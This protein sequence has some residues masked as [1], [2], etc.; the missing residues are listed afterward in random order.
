MTSSIDERGTKACGKREKR[1]LGVSSLAGSPHANI[2]AADSC[3]EAAGF[4]VGW[5]LG[6]EHTANCGQPKAV[7]VGVVVTGTAAV[8][9]D[10][11]IGSEILQT[12]T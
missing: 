3:E 1:L 5:S 11:G 7:L 4:E 9:L 12:G 6:R 8:T 10:E 2:T